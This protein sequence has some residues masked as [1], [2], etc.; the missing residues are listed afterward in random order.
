MRLKKILRLI[1]IVE[2]SQINELKISGWG[3]H[4]VEIAVENG[5]PVEYNQVLF[6]II[7]T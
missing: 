5:H 4:I 1:Q 3:Q 7:S 2:N 6:Q